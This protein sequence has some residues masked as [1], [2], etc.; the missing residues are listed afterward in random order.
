MKKL[1][2]ILLASGAGFT[3]FSQETESM[4]DE[5]SSEWIKITIPVTRAANPRPA[6]AKKTTT[7]KKTVTP[8]KKVEAPKP[9]TTDEFNKT[10]SKVNRFKK[11]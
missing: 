10:N 7:A 2:F 1:F 3:C 8:P 5:K 4:T 9:E 6:T 11:G